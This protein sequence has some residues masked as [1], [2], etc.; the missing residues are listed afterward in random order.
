ML[1]FSLFCFLRFELVL[2]IGLLAVDDLLAELDLLDESEDDLLTDVVVFFDTVDPAGTFA[3]LSDLGL[4]TSLLAWL[5][6]L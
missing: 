2:T 3:L 5:N 6:E 1:R 4:V